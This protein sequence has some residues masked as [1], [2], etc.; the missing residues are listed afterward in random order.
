M[1]LSGGLIVGVLV[2]FFAGAGIVFA[3]SPGFT[4][5]FM[6][7]E[8]D[9]FSSVGDNPFFSLEPGFQ[10]VLEGEEDGE[11][12]RLVITVLDETKTI[13]GVKTRVV[14]ERET[15]DGELVEV[16]KNYFAI[17]NRDN[18]VVYFGEDVNIY[19]SGVVVSHEGSWR[20]GVNGAKPGII[21]PGIQLLGARYMQEIA[22]GVALDRAETVSISE[23]VET[24]AGTFENCLKTKET[25]PLEPGAVEFKF[26]APDIGLIQDGELKLVDFSEGDVD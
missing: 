5:S 2:A 23:V 21:M 15:A 6:F 3:H 19:E 7:E 17:C 11:E 8:C 16:S 14:R 10:L 20:A 25:T 4:D 26:Y 24:P 1:K 22:P 18:S 9:G 12:V 13:D